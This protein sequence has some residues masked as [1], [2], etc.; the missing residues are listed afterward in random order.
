VLLLGET[1]PGRA[2]RGADAI[3]ILKVDYDAKVVRVLGLPP[4]LWVDTPGLAAAQIPATTLTNTYYEAEKLIAGSDRAKMAYAT[5]VFAQTL[6]DNFGFIPDH[7]ISIS[8][9]AFRNVIDTMDGLEIDV[10]RAVDG[11]PFGFPYFSAGK[12]VM[13]G[14]TALDYMRIGLATDLASVTE[15]GWRTPQEQVLQAL[16][17]QLLQPQMLLKLPQLIWRFHEDVVTDLSLQQFFN[18]GCMLQAEDV[19][20]EYVPLDQGL[21][22][23]ARNNVLVPDVAGIAALLDAEFMQ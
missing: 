18:L 8:Q 20:V 9:A 21:V 16:N 11:R 23:E 2:V 15:S 22:S 17:D 4:D 13:D 5:N 12:Q 10:P 6:A 7:Y 19:P 1:M 14:E 3:R